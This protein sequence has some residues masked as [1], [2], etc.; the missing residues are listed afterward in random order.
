MFF[1]YEAI[2]RIIGRIAMPIFAFMIAEGC[3]YTKNK[4]RYLSMILGLAAVYQGA[5]YF[6]NGKTTM[7]ILVTFSL[8][9]I[10]IY[11][12]Q[13]FYKMLF[14]KE[15]SLLKKGLGGIALLASIGLTVAFTRKFQVDYYIYGC[16]LPL[17]ASLAHFPESAPAK[18]KR[19]DTNFTSVLLLGIGAVVLA[20]RVPF[21]TISIAGL[22]VRIQLF[23]VIAILLL[24][25]YNGKR[26]KY[27]MKYFFY[28][29]Y[30]VHLLILELIA[31]VVK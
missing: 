13:Y 21:Y 25:F 27:K 22:S 9:I 14:Q 30:P 3:R 29:F 17:L 26:G 31:N 23:S 1:P 6:Y 28:I 24:F 19:I 10:M 5:Y 18:L 16:M 12:L 11:A 2:F 20:L 15:A 8:S 4:I 7:C